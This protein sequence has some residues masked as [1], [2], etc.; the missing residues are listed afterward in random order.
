MIQ[1]KA[2]K[3]TE[4]DRICYRH[5]GDFL[6]SVKEIVSM[7]N[8]AANLTTNVTQL[9]QDFSDT[10]QE[11][12]HVLS[13]LDKLNSERESIRRGLEIAEQCRDLA[14][15]MFEARKQILQEDHYAAL[16]TIDKIQN[17]FRSVPVSTLSVILDEW[18]PQAV[19]QILD[20]VRNEADEYISAMRSSSS[21]YGRI[22]L[23]RQAQLSA[24]LNKRGG[25]TQLVGDR[26]SISLHHVRRFG[27]VF[28]LDKWASANEF[29]SISP[30]IYALDDADIT[31]MNSFFEDLAPLHK[32]LYTYNVLG[33]QSQFHV[34]YRAIRDRDL[35]AII[36]GAG[37][38]EGI[39]W[40]SAYDLFIQVSL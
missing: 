12:V 32:A 24:V 3:E 1:A 7:R 18:L 11:L 37:K 13:E 36:D 4:I 14:K 27:N 2:K 28:R 15:L 20:G 39:V 40:E 34:H 25:R 30:Y 16:H 10:G 31:L 9:H 5:Y 35:K 26:F 17:D 8:S 19:A 23:H 29:E 33:R 6:A 22:L 38:Q 21:N